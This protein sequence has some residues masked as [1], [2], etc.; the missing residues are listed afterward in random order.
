MYSFQNLIKQ[1]NK[2]TLCS[3]N[4]EMAEKEKEKEKCIPFFGNLKYAI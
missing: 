1:E 4:N 3:E 2:N